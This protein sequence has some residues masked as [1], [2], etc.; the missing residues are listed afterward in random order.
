MKLYYFTL[1]PYSQKA[2]IALAE[3]GA[4]Y[5]AVQ[6]DLGDAN[7]RAEFAKI[8]RLGKLPFLVD[9]ARDWKVPESSIIIEYIDRHCPGGTQ[10]IPSDPELSRQ[11]RFYDRLFDLYV[12]EPA[13]KLFFDARRAEGQHDTIGVE[14]AQKRLDGTYALFDDA[15]AKKKWVLGDTFS[16]GDVAAAPA[17]AI[18]RMMRPFDA[19]KNLVA[20]LGR[21]SERESVQRVFK[22]AQE[23][24]A[25][26]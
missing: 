17:L 16:I 8:N 13:L 5:E 10:L 26:R 25:R 15:L 11:A 9:E 2:L 22:Q 23:A 7:A 6:V 21:L 18:A 12:T 1:S 24:M 19:H 3:K 20:Y 4:K 14:A